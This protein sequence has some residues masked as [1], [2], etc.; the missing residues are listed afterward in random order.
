MFI[1]EKAGLNVAQVALWAV[2]SRCGWTAPVRASCQFIALN[3]KGADPQV[4]CST[5]GCFRSGR[6]G[7]HLRG[8][9][10]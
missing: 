8:S 10:G 6:G 2:V 5:Q 4:I 9:A 1:E 3:P 7:G